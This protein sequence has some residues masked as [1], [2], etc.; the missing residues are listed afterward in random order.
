MSRIAVF[1]A[2]YVGLVTG[3]CFA[4]LGHDVVVRDVVPETDRGACGGQDADPRARSG[5]RDRARRRAA[6]L[7]TRRR[8]GARRGGDRVRRVGTPPTYSGDAGPVRG[9]DGR[10]T[11][12][13]ADMRATLVMKSTVPPARAKRCGRTLDARGLVRVGVRLEPR[14][15]LRGHGRSRLH[16]API[17]SSSARS[18]RTHG[19]PSGRALRAARRDDRAD[20]RRL[21]GDDQAR[22]ERVPRR[23]GSA[24]STR[25]RASA[26]S[27]ARTW[28][29][30][31][32]G[33]GL[34][35][36]SDRTT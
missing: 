11:S 3:G 14:V 36:R 19:E 32:N 26:S 12:C 29:D 9:L 5:G 8:R 28:Y 33:I 15:S 7:H 25:S 20:G 10:S 30:V 13:R 24:S 22:L 35:P 21:C 16:A 2:G 18:S 1:G 31:A 27:S 34:D 4:D 17:A 6:S 23:P